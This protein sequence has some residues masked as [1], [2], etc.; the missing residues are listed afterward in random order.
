MTVVAWLML[1]WLALRK[2]GDVKGMDSSVG[3][4]TP[5]ELH[6]ALRDVHRPRLVAFAFLFLLG[7]RAATEDAA[8]A[9]LVA[10]AGRT[11]QLRHPERAAAWLRRH[12][13]RS[14][15]FTRR[16][17]TDG[18]AALAR[19]G[20][21]PAS[22]AG[23][24]ALDRL[25]RAT[26]IAHLV[27]GLDSR[28][29]ETIIDHSPRQLDVLLSRARSKYQRGRAGGGAVTPRRQSGPVHVGL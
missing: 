19:V 26:L 2:R 12:V 14:S 8:D 25:E 29:V 22:Q 21:T 28:D 1:C 5:S 3:R 11:D 17:S 7:E 27:E 18:R 15:P 9:A 24:A 4:P 13:V 23:L 6:A 10:A 16:L 20:V